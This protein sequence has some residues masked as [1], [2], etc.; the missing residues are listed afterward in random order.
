MLLPTHRHA[1]RLAFLPQCR[2]VR[3]VICISTATSSDLCPR[4]TGGSSS[5]DPGTM[6]GDRSGSPLSTDDTY[7]LHA[8][9]VIQ[10]VAPYDTSRVH[11]RLLDVSGSSCRTVYR[12][13]RPRR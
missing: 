1:L 3:K 8:D 2:A 9:T 11:D 7:S 10:Q 5:H 6:F 12:F 13:T 4:I